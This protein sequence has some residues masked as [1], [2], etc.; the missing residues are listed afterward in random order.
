MPADVEPS[1]RELRRTEAVRLALAGAAV[2]CVV[3]AG[4]VLWSR[5]GDAV[6]SSLVLSALAWCF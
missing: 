5:S 2:L 3:G 1:T 4:L 6:F